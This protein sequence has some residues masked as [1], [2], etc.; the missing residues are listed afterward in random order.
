MVVVASI[1]LYNPPALINNPY[2]PEDQPHT[3]TENGNESSRRKQ[4]QRVFRPSVT[5]HPHSQD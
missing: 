4:K 5:A 2:R 3:S 1:T